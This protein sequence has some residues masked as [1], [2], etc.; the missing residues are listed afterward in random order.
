MPVLFSKHLKDI[1][2]IW[3]GDSQ[4]TIC[5]FEKYEI[6]KQLPKQELDP[7]R[8]GIFYENKNA[9]WVTC[10][11]AYESGLKVEY[12]DMQANF[13]KVR[14]IAELLWSSYQTR[15]TLKHWMNTLKKVSWILCKVVD[16]NECMS[17]L[18]SSF[19]SN[20]LRITSSIYSNYR[21]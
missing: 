4:T 18:I 6:V 16:E 1:F 17:I 7:N 20:G 5:F 19:S 12:H 9:S 3:R 15:I 10:K 14:D 21:Y 2:Y 13:F 11:V 8:C